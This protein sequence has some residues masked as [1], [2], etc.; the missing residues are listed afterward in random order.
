MNLDFPVLFQSPDE[1]QVRLEVGSWAYSNWTSATFSRSIETCASAFTVS[2]S[3]SFPFEQ[4]Q[5]GFRPGDVVRLYLDDELA[6]TGYIDSVDMDHQGTISVSGRSK[7]G[8]LVDCSALTFSIKKTTFKQAAE[9][10]AAPYSVAVQG[11]TG[12]KLPRLNVQRGDTVW[13]ALDKRAAKAG[14]LLMDTRTGDLLITRAGTLRATTTIGP[15]CTS[16]KVQFTMS[17]RFKRYEVKGVVANDPFPVGTEAV[18]ALGTADDAECPLERT[19]IIKAKGLGSRD[20]AIRYA[21]WEAATRYGKSTTLTYTLPGWRM[22]DG[23]L[24]WVNQIADVIDEQH[25]IAGEYLIASAK[26]TKDQ[27]GSSVELTLHPREA[28]LPQPIPRGKGGN[29]NVWIPLGDKVTPFD[30]STGGLSQEQTSTPK[31][32]QS[33]GL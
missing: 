16:S 24:W 30:P 23:N 4:N 21:Q 15:S 33:G 32:G 10:L 11:E 3:R 28:F 22:A 12:P 25:N 7:T 27:S 20:D 19:L 26:Y 14:L 13:A 17:G 18:D 8:Q 5:V 1:G 2:G 31:A 6:M 9:I 29:K